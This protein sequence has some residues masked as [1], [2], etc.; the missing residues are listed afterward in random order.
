MASSSPANDIDDGRAASHA[1]LRVRP[2]MP[3]CR[4]IQSRDANKAIRLWAAGVAVPLLSAPR[5][6]LFFPRLQCAAVL[7][8]IVRLLRRYEGGKEGREL[9]KKS[10]TERS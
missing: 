8:S 4:S 10:E 1:L 2:S 6:W 5:T 3:T 7:G 9:D